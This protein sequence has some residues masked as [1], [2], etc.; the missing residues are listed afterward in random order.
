[1]DRFLGGVFGLVRGLIV[2]CVL[3]MTLVAFAIKTEAVRQS[4]FAP[5]ITTGARALALVMPGG[6]REQFRAGFEKFKQAL[7]QGDKKT[8]KN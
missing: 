8:P 3:L 6:L 5:Y 7:I 4:L 1:M 2:D